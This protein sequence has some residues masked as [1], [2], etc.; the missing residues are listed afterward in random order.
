MHVNVALV[1]ARS[2]QL[3]QVATVS[4]IPAEVPVKC[5]LHDAQERFPTQQTRALDFKTPEIVT[6]SALVFSQRENSHRAVSDDATPLVPR[7]GFGKAVH[8]VAEVLGSH[9]AHD[10]VRALEHV[11]HLERIVD[12]QGVRGVERVRNKPSRDALRGEPSR[13]VVQHSK[14]VHVG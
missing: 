12:A 5:G 10:V 11:S 7:D 1:G 6:S 8:K 13:L 4:V 3:S 2:A 9:R 14:L